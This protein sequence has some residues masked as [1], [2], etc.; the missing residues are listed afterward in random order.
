MS[1]FKR[2]RDEA[3]DQWQKLVDEMYNDDI[4]TVINKINTEQDPDNPP[5]PNIINLKKMVEYR[6]N[7]ARKSQDSDE[8]EINYE[9]YNTTLRIC[10]LVENIC[11]S[12]NNDILNENIISFL[13]SNDYYGSDEF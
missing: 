2:T 8:F 3:C 7:E 6:I 4:S 13:K 5:L 11:N 9:K 12:E 10:M 1:E